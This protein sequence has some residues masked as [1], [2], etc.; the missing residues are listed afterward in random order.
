MQF[1]ASKHLKLLPFFT[2]L[3]H[4]Q[5]SVTA[6][7]PVFFVCGSSNYTSGS[8]YETNLNTILPTL[9]S[10][11][12]IRRDSFYNNSYGD[13]TNMVYS[14]SQCMSAASE[15]DCRQ[16]LINSTAE[17]IRRCPNK[18]EATIRYYS[19]ILR[20]SDQRF[21]SELDTSIRIS[22]YPVQDVA[23]VTLF[24]TQ[25]SGL[26]NNLTT[27]AASAA[28]KYA[29]SFTNYDSFQRIYGLAQCTRDLSESNC[30]N[31]LRRMIENIPSCCD[32]RTGGNVYSVS[33]NIRYDMYIF[34][35]LPPPPAPPPPVATDSPAPDGSPSVNRTQGTGIV[36]HNS[37]ILCLLQ[38]NLSRLTCNHDF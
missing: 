34:F 27:A 6:D 8:Q 15:D 24:N 11:G 1:Q 5:S 35:S 2:L 31:C 29:V 14:Y 12:V 23:N 17:I 13:D 16:C 22:L 3:L 19:C 18:T 25:A 32:G 9:S 33:C 20:Y 10:N 28:S 37:I 7:E 26:M 38:T 36:E 30:D 4:F 21:F